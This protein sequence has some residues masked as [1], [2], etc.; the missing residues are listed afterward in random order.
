MKFLLIR[1]GDPSR[2]SRHFTTTPS[3]MPPLGLLYIGAALEKE[4]HSIEVLDSYMENITQDKLKSEIVKSDAV[5]VTVFTSD[6]KASKEISKTIRDIDSDIPFIIGGPHCTFVKERA[7]KDIPHADYSIVGEGERVVVDFAKFLQE[8]K[9]IKDIHGINYRN[10]GSIKTA[11]PLQIICNLDEL[12]FPASHLV[13]KYDYGNF[14]FGF[15]LKKKVTSM[16]TSRGCPFHCRFCTRYN[17]LFKEWGF[18]QRSA[19]SILKEFEQ[20]DKKY[21]SVNIVDDNFLANKKRANKIFDGLIEMDK[22]MEIVIHGARVDSANEELYKKMKKAGVKSIFFGIESGN[23]DVLDFYKKN[24]TIPQIKKAVNL[25][26]KMNFITVGNFIL[27]APIETKQ[28]IENT[29]NFACSLPLDIAGF[30]PLVYHMGSELWNE[31]VEQKKISKDTN[32]VWADKEKGLGNFT[33]QE[34]LNYTTIAF[35]RFYLRPSYL[36]GQVYKRM[37][38]GDYRLLF[39]GLRFLFLIKKIG[40]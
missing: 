7:L 32:I 40:S 14:P 4:G 25:S 1:P 29:I 31:A 19:E 8:K 27:G 17:I 12:P 9:N 23:Q 39:Y 38:M 34:L 15:K 21:G 26:K 22:N 13:D 24:I 2:Y 28:H 20:M 37:S 36:M 16:M 3:T 33:I 5:G 10:N 35:Q 6:L 11:K 30:G 18:R